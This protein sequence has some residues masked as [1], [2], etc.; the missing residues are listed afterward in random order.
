MV[1]KHNDAMQHQKR[2]EPKN[3]TA[4]MRDM[5]LAD[6]HDG[7]RSVCQEVRCKGRIGSYGQ[8]QLSPRVAQSEVEHAASIKDDACGLYEAQLCIFSPLSTSGSNGI[9]DV[10]TCAGHVR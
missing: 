1:R 9:T 2:T 8:G 7:K 5:V 6:T 4:H 10:S 3:T